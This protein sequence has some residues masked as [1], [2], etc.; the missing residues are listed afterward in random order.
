MDLSHLQHLSSTFFAPWPRHFGLHGLGNFAL[1]F[2]GV[3]PKKPFK[4]GGIKC[5]FF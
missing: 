3:F 2:F 4:E 1:W 5:L